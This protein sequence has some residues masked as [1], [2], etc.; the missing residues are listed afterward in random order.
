MGLQNADVQ[1][2]DGT[3]HSKTFGDIYFAK[4]GPAET[5]HVFLDGNQLPARFSIAVNFTIGELGFGTGLNFLV[6]WEAWKKT[7]KPEN[8]R[9]NFFSVE[10][11][12]IDADTLAQA[13]GEWPHLKDLS[14]RLRNAMPPYVEG[15]H[16]VSLGDN[17]TLILGYGDALEIL[18]RMH[19]RVEAW[20]LDGF[21]PSE[22]PAMWSPDILHQVARLSA[23]DATFGTFTVAGSVRRALQHAGFQIERRDG[24]RRKREMLAGRLA[25]HASLK[26]GAPWFN[27]KRH[28]EVPVKAGSRVAVIGAGISGASLSHELQRS[29]IGVEI[30]DANGI[31]SGA[32]GNPAGLIMPR[33]DLGDTPAARFFKSAY[34][35]VVR[36][37]DTMPASG[38]VNCGVSH[39]GQTERDLSRLKRIIS[40]ELLPADWAEAT[41]HGVRYPQAGV[42]DPVAFVQSLIADTRVVQKRVDRID[43]MN[44]EWRV[45]AGD[46]QKL[47]DGVII[48]NGLDALRF[49]QIRGLP[50][51][52]SAGQIDWFSHAQPP[53]T[54]YAFGPYAA[55]CPSGG[56][57]IGATYAPIAIGQEPQFSREATQSNLDA[58]ARH[59]PSLVQGLMPDASVSRVAIRC[60]T[61]DRLP[62]VGGVPD[63][64]FYAGAYDG[65]RTG[66]RKEYPPG[67]ALSGLYVLTG[68]GSRGLV[69]APLC[70]AAIAAEMT[71]APSPIDSEVAEA[72]HPARFFIRDLKRGTRV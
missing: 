12:P 31:A 2:L 24:F 52:G 54:A 55:P 43:R 16:R 47:Y 18:S 5:K 1:W 40:A 13:H 71:G 50:L 10:K 20:F 57:I 17:V 34:L 45:V 58:V 27:T 69:T 33:L 30:Y 60:T 39:Q 22:N 25:D 59:D 11:H 70:A 53:A 8:A 15:I 49:A 64:G 48:A 32:S 6:A 26:I 51:A 62:V 38:Y 63:W 14:G 68:L 67:E 21:A 61:P 3:L 42:I 56:L 7:P 9:L 29:G 35:H 46:D 41:T 37:L 65:L 36:L 23:S 19:A 4:D 44:G 28:H 66:L 72:L